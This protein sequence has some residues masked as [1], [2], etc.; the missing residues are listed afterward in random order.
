MEGMYL[1]HSLS[2]GKGTGK[3]RHLKTTLQVQGKVFKFNMVGEVEGI[4]N[5]DMA[6]AVY[7]EDTKQQWL[8]FDSSF[9]WHIKL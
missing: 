3:R 7:D 5:Q 1:K 9:H 8:K 4:V 2:T 6:Q